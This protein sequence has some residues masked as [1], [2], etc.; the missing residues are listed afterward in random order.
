MWAPSTNTAA[1]CDEL[2]Q[3]TNGPE[4]PLMGRSWRAPSCA[5]GSEAESAE[6]NGGSRHP[7]PSPAT[8]ARRGT[9]RVMLSR[10]TAAPLSW[11]TP[12][13]ASATLW[14]GPYWGYIGV[15]SLGVT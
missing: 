12:Q 13:T 10:S 4:C 5:A 6:Q 11:E 8:S 7:C 3:G 9:S 14:F 15:I 1:G 2:F